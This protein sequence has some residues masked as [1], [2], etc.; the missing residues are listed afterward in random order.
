ML[1]ANGRT[2]L[3]LAFLLLPQYSLMAFSSAAEPLR[4]ANRM[5]G[6]ALF[7]WSLVSPDGAPIQASNSMLS[8]VEYGLQ[9]TPPA[10]LILVLASDQPMAAVDARM[11]GWLRRRALAGTYLAAADTGAYVLARAGLL[12]GYKATVH[13]EA[14]EDFR[15]R[16]PSVQTR[17]ALYV[18]DRARMTAAGATACLD[19]ILYIIECRHGRD[20]AVSVAEQFVYSPMRS[21]HAAQRH[22]LDQRL[23]CPNPNVRRAVALMET[24]IEDTLST[25]DLADHLDISLRE[26]ERVFSRWLGITPGAYYRRLR[27]ERA[28]GLLEQ[29]QQSVTDI[30]FRCGFASLPSFSRCYRHAYGHNPSAIRK[31]HL[32]AGALPS[33]P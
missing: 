5:A 26:L 22:S 28:R 25:R 21:A 14:L 7:Q 31:R 19:L 24:R 30:A 33:K 27:L 9:N 4:A 20:L 32:R 10:D 17:E 8:V 18:V 6:R 1:E 12:N 3:K 15:D 2:P 29:G 16:F 11:L 23:Q 13:W